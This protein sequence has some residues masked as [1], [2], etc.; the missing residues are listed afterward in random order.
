M[1]QLGRDELIQLYEKNIVPKPARQ[2]GCPKHESNGA[3]EETVSR[4]STKLSELN[5]HVSKRQDA[6]H[7]MQQGRRKMIRLNLPGPGR[8]E[9]SMDTSSS[10]AHHVVLKRKADEDQ[11]K[12]Q[13]P[14]KRQKI[15]WP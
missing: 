12:P 1:H 3:N 15:T 6:A 13:Q 2:R 7:D 8:E 9:I 5:S 14:Q 4:L 10:S 11:H